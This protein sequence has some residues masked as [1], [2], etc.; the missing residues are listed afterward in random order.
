[1]AYSVEVFSLVDL[2]TAGSDHR[3]RRVGFEKNRREG[4]GSQTA[5]SA[6]AQASIAPTPPS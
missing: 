1:M 4:K 3:W 2:S 5:S 6:T